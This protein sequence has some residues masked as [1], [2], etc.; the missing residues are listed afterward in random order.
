MS[1]ELAALCLRGLFEITFGDPFSAFFILAIKGQASVH[2]LMDPI[3]LQTHNTLEALIDGQSK[4]SASL[5]L[6]FKPSEE[7]GEQ[8]VVVTHIREW[9]LASWDY[10]VMV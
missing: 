7:P 6:L 9:M 10:S 1:S 2:I 8:R 4:D 3:K 5:H